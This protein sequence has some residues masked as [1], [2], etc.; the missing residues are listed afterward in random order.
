MGLEG[1]G[2]G[3]LAWLGT[4]FLSPTGHWW[5]ALIGTGAGPQASLARL[6]S[7]VLSFCPVQNPGVVG[8]QTW[9]G[10][11]V[12]VGGSL[13]SAAGEPGVGVGWAVGWGQVPYGGPLLIWGE[14]LGSP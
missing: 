1:S 10:E 2:R 3:A 8:G 7:A 13:L 11:G 5:R 4:D 14:L 6:V 12:E 9:Q